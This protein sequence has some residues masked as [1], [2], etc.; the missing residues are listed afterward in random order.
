[1]TIATPTK[2][3]GTAPGPDSCRRSLTR[4]VERKCDNVIAAVKVDLGV[5]ARTDHDVLLAIHYVRGGRRINAGTGVEIPQLLAVGRIIGRELAVAF[6]GENK[7]AGGGKN[8][9]DHRLR[10]LDL[11]FELD[12]VVVDGRDV[13]G[14]LFARD[15]LEGAAKPQ[16]AVRIRR[17]LDKVVHGLMQVDGVGKLL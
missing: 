5:A 15:H 16:L 17:V 6:A 13:A 1:M 14:L 4:S 9:A 10:R 11:P 8:A 12:G 3:I 2:R 7:S